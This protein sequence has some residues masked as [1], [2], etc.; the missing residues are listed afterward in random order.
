MSSALDPSDGGPFP[1]PRSALVLTIGAILATALMA[2]VFIGLGAIAAIGLGHALAVGA[3][4]T[5]A[6]RRV[7]EPQAERI[8]LRGFD[9][10]LLPLILCL[11]PIVLLARELDNVAADASPE[12]AEP[13]ET[14]ADAPVDD[15]GAGAGA[16]AGESGESG[17]D[18]LGLDIDLD[19]P[20]TIAQ[21]FVIYVG[22]APVIEEFFFRGVL[23]QGL[24]ARLG[25]VRGVGLVALLFTLFHL[26][27][28]SSVPRLLMRLLSSFGMG[29]VLGLVRL[30]TGSILG[31]ILLSSLWAAI[32]ILSFALEDDVALPGMNVEGTHLPLGVTFVSLLLVAWAIRIVYEQAQRRL[33]DERF[34]ASTTP[35]PE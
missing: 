16:G 28:A 20:W 15:A 26:P 14:R 33:R 23:Q 18:P 34:E 2:V 13:A 17:E 12:L 6:A 21:A 25:L 27:V 5:W 11:V 22:I 35:R 7:A 30:A 29:A 10:R 24:V 19:D 9:L 1:D 31:S 3:I 4:A 32:G 8:G